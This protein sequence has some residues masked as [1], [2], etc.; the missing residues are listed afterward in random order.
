MYHGVLGDEAERWLGEAAKAD[1]ERY[2]E[3]C[4]RFPVLSSVEIRRALAHEVMAGDGEMVEAIA[5][6]TAGTRRAVTSCRTG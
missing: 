2:G 1:P 6:A 5:L 4:R 3:V